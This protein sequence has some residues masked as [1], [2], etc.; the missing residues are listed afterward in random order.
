MSAP[1]TLYSPDGKRTREIA[2]ID[3]PGWIRAGW[4]SQPPVIPPVALT[5][6]SEP[7]ESPVVLPVTQTPVSEPEELIADVGQAS[8]RGK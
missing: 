1:V 8:K 6:V 2:A 3:A 4:L 7:E 5:P